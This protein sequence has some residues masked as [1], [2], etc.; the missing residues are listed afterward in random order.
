VVI[1]AE[2][3]DD[4][5]ESDAGR[6]ADRSRT[7]ELVDRAADARGAGG[8]ARAVGECR[9]DGG[10]ERVYRR[11]YWGGYRDAAQVVIECFSLDAPVGC[12]HPLEAAA[13]SPASFCV[14]DTGKALRCCI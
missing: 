9:G 11:R 14:G 1:E 13:D 6:V 3:N 5:L 2:A 8:A 4:A 7:D 12:H 10:C